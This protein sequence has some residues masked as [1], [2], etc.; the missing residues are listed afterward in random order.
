MYLEPVTRSLLRLLSYY[1]VLVVAALVLGRFSPAVH[2]AIAFEMLSGD[3][4]RQLQRVS[5]GGAEPG[6][7][8]G[9]PTRGRAGPAVATA[10]AMA[11]AGCPLIP[12][13]SVY[14]LTHRH[15]RRDPSGRPTLSLPPPALARSAGCLRAPP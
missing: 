8:S 4:T 7:A 10:L 13:A 2:D 15:P 12:L 11:G 5:E 14:L 1:V 3:T 6:E 9:V